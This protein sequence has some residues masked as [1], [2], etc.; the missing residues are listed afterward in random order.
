MIDASPFAIA[1]GTAQDAGIPQP[2]CHRACCEAARRDRTIERLPACLGLV[3]PES[4]RA[5][6]IDCTPRFP[7]QLERLL[8]H[9]GTLAGILLTHAHIGHYTGLV[10]LGREAMATSRM[11]VWV[12]PRMEQFLRQNA[13]WS[14]LVDLGHIELRPLVPDEPVAL[15]SSVTVTPWL[16]PHRD[17]YSETCAFLIEGPSCRIFY[18]PDIDAWARW[19]RD[20]ADVLAGVDVALLDGCFFDDAELGH[21]DPSVI[22]HPRITHT[23][24][25][26]ASLPAPERAKIHFTHLNH[27]NAAATP[28][29]AQAKKVEEASCHVA[30]EGQLWAL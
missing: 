10:Y 2:G 22:P 6:M 20:L 19:E 8:A 3:D 14:G 23:L 4:S 21:R 17:E 16:V 18:V 13:P 25:L 11:P 15:T 9:C 26:A 5:F 7:R 28:G 30:Q 12:L 24:A 29:S 27:T 1:L